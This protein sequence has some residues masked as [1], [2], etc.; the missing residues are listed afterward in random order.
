[1]R[2]TVDSHERIANGEITCTYR[3]WKRP[4]VKVGGRYHVGAV[5]LV[6]DSIDEVRLEEVSDRDARR[7]GFADRDALAT[8]LRKRAPMVDDE[9]VWHVEFEFHAVERDDRPSLADA[10]DLTDAD[11]TDIQA[12]LDRLDARSDAG[13]WT[14]A[15]LELI[16][17]NPELVSTE[18]AARLGRERAPFKTDVRK[19][20]RLGLTVSLEVGYRLSPRGE[21][22]LRR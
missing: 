1:M 22:F 17:D 10:A 9:R 2:F 13:P 12:R 7:S 8:F 15:T 5:D 4:Q 14:R 20:K 16:G 11:V 6:V 19:L 3:A 21:A 18:L